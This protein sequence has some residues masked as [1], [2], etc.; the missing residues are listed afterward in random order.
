MT[1][2]EGTSYSGNWVQSK[3]HGQGT[4]IHPKWR[5]DG[6]W[7]NDRKEGHGKL[8]FGN[9]TGIGVKD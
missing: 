2:T 8:D 6:E 5:Y 7:V 1:A 3:R 4:E 9:G